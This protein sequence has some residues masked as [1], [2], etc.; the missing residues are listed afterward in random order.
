MDAL[1]NKR[2]RILIDGSNRPKYV[3]HA[4]ATQ[5]AMSLVA[6]P[7][8]NIEWKVHDNKKDK[9]FWIQFVTVGADGTKQP[10]ASPFSGDEWPERKEAERERS[11]GW[12]D[13]S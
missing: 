5:G 8:E 12:H 1:V 10:S 3:I 11:A 6:R 13:R 7:Q 4:D 9:E 2:L